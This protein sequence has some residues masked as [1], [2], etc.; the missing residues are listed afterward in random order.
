MV[1]E[2]YVDDEDQLDTHTYTLLDSSSAM[3]TTYFRIETYSTGDESNY[4]NRLVRAWSPEQRALYR[5]PIRARVILDH[6]V[7]FEDEN[8]N[9]F[10]LQIRVQDSGVPARTQTLSY[11]ISMVNINEQITLTSRTTYVFH[12]RR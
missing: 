9:E 4:Q 11:S 3:A 1:G 10:T 6:E 7:D 8:P 2:F 5:S 12:H